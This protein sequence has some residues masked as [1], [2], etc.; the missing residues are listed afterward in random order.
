MPP[1]P[2]PFRLVQ[3][4]DT[5]LSRSHAYFQDNWD[6]FVE[7]MAEEKPDMVLVTGDLCINGPIQADDFKYA[8]EQMER[9]TV[10]WRAIPGNHDAGETPPDARLGKPITPARRRNWLKVFGDDYWVE[11][12]GDWRFIGLNAQLMESGLDGEAEQ[13][14]MLEEALASAGTRPVAIANH[15]PLWRLTADET[16]KSLSAMWPKSRQ[17]LMRLCEKHKVKLFMSGHLHTYRTTRHKGTRLIWAPSSAFVTLSKGNWGLK[18]VRRLG[19]VR[20]RFE[21]RNFTH[22]LVRPP[23]FV[24]IDVSNWQSHHGSTTN[25]PPRP[26]GRHAA[27]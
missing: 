15:K 12:W 1:L 7:A 2:S 9:L 13:K 26:L 16:G 21:G 10:P 17:Y 27:G 14:A 25:L 5:H 18:M 22:E 24:D 3:I 19:Y 11:D 23:R 6:V 8:R 20:Y 4:S